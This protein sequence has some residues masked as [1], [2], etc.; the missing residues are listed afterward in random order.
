MTYKIHQFVRRKQARVASQNY[1]KAPHKSYSR[2]PQIELPFADTDPGLFSTFKKRFSERSGAGS[3]LSYEEL[4][5]VLSSVRETV[6]SHRTYP[7]GGAFYPIET[8]VLNNYQTPILYHYNPKKHCLEKLLWQPPGSAI[9]NQILN[10]SDY[11]FDCLIILTSNYTAQRA[12]YKDRSY[13][14]QLLEAGHMGQNIL[15]ASTAKGLHSCPFAGFEDKVINELLDLDTERE[16]PVYVIG[17]GK[18]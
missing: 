9:S 16:Y 4:G 17:I 8:Y 14:L 1:F 18:K 13:Q 7:S 11:Q 2:F 3:H 10:K 15:L 5:F 12:K 6:D